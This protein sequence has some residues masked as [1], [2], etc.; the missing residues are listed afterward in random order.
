VKKLSPATQTKIKRFMQNEA[1]PLEKYLYLSHFENGAQSDVLAALARFQNA[2]GGFGHALE[3][4]LRL[5]ESSVIAT[6]IAF[7]H[8]RELG[9]HEDSPIL[10]NACRYLVDNYNADTVNWSV[11]PATVDNA[12]HAPWWNY[13]GDVSRSQSNP[14][15]EILG[16]LYEYPDQLP[17]HMRQQVSDSVLAYLLS[18]PDSLEMHD[19]M[20]YIRLYETPSLPE[21]LKQILFDKLK[22]VVENV[23]SR[24]PAQWAGYGL[25]PLTVVNSPTSPFAFLFQNELAANLDFMID[26]LDDA[27]YWNPNWFWGDIW[28][29]AWAQAEKDWRGVLTLANLRIL[30]AFDRLG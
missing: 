20:C 23:V 18:Q 29:D 6:T 30:G 28:P 3:P 17:A 14:R 27:G 16:Y 2:D 9:I 21:T 15:A 1:R 7:Q 26:R 24:D 25:P 4:D 19:L 13:G 11:V 10:R 5:Q 8:F 12:P 22:R